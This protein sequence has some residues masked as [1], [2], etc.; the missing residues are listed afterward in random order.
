MEVDTTFSY[1][2]PPIFYSGNCQALVVRMTVY[3]DAINLWEV[4]EKDYNVP[5]LLT[6]PTMNQLKTRKE[7]KTKKSKAKAC[8]FSAISRKIFTRIMNLGSTKEIWVSL[9]KEY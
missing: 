2:A 9:K 5:S 6:N 3:L 4:V 1:I 7:K 8:I